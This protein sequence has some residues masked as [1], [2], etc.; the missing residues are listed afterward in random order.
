M[1]IGATETGKK[2]SFL[3]NFCLHTVTG[4]LFAIQ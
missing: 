2:V 4:Y 3:A 1:H